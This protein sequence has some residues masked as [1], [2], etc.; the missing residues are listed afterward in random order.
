VAIYYRNV[1]RSRLLVERWEFNL[2]RQAIRS[3]AL[4]RAE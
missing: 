2:Q 3:E 4:Y 1:T